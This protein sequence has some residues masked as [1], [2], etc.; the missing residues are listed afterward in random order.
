MNVLTFTVT[1]D[2]FVNDI[3]LC[4]VK[5]YQYIRLYNIDEDFKT[6]NGVVPVKKIICE[7][8]DVE[9]GTPV[10]Y[11]LPNIIGVS[12]SVFGIKTETPS[13]EGKMLTADN[14]DKCVLEY[15]DVSD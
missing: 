5:N 3:C 12:N 14:I 1:A 15:Y 10:G 8:I 13:L 6:T 9:S 4:Q 11:S 7:L 2:A